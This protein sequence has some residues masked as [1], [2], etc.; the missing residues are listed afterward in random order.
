M[1]RQTILNYESSAAAFNGASTKGSPFGSPEWN[2]F[3]ANA[4]KKHAAAIDAAKPVME[5]LRRKHHARSA[6]LALVVGV[7]EDAPAAIPPMP[8]PED[9][10]WR[11]DRP[12]ANSGRGSF[13]TKSQEQAY[14]DAFDRHVAAV[15]GQTPSPVIVPRNNVPNRYDRGAL[16]DFITDLPTLGRAQKHFDRITSTEPPMS[17][18]GAFRLMLITYCDE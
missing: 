6:E 3:S 4:D 14:C 13:E 12:G 18:K 1:S 11:P 7:Y 10:G 8:K 5:K 9:Y 2:E 15:N 17:V 16:A